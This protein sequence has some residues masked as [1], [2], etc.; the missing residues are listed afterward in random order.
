MNSS[1]LNKQK[2]QYPCVFSTG[3]THT[4]FGEVPHYAEGLYDLGKGIYAWMVPNGS[5]GEANSGLVVGKDGSLLIDTLW[6]MTYTRHMLYAI[7][8]LTAQAPIECVVNT[9]ADGDHFWG[10]ALVDDLRTIASKAALKE[11]AHTKPKHMVFFQTVG[12][13]F[14]LAP[15][16]N[17]RDVGHWFRAMCAPYNF[18]DVVHTP[19]KES[20]SGE[21]KLN[22]SGREVELIEVGPAHTAGDVMVHIPDAKTLFTADILFIN[23]T[24][25]M[26]A[27]PVENWIK[28]LDK[29]LYMD[30]DIIVPGHG[31]ITQ[32]SGVQLVKDYWIYV[33]REARRHFDAGLSATQAAHEI[34]MS[35]NFSRQ[36]FASWDSPERVMTNCHVLF[37]HFNN[38]TKPLKPIEKVNILRHQAILAHAL[39]NASPK[40]MRRV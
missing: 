31:P 6:D 10:N 24:P 13:F 34:V 27:G 21:L 18:K 5:W 23:S 4:R 22:I 30:V 20:F 11:M 7:N 2:I 35:Q 16:K 38:N 1:A 17:A 33:S 26:W 12:R 9:H 8:S 3:T 36:V 37:R 15:T 14:S 25:V 40:S 32:K 28:A 29:I 19:A 39:P